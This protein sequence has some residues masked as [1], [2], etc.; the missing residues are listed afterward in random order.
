LPDNYTIDIKG[1]KELR[2]RLRR[3]DAEMETDMM[4]TMR[5]T[6][7][8]V[9]LPR[10]RRY[11]GKYPKRMQFKSEKQRRFVMM[12]V[13]QGKVPYRRSQQLAGAWGTEVK[14]VGNDVVGTLFNDAP[15]AP[16]VKGHKAVGASGPQAAYHK[17]NWK[18]LGQDLRD[19]RDE[20]RQVWKDF[21]KRWLRK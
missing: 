20:I 5:A 18:T 14:S 13:R 19:A 11:P 12:L 17:G 1:I 21:V 15:H 8:S 16:W 10:A 9:L 7:E 2:A 3:M 4:R 6:V